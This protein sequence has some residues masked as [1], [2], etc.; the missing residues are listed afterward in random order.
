VSTLSARQHEVLQLIARGL[1]NQEIGDILKISGETVRTHVAAVLVRLEVSNR[2]EAAVAYLAWDAGADRVALALARPALA[3]LPLVVLASDAHAATVALGIAYDLVVLFSRWC[4]FP[5]IANASTQGSRSLG[6]DSREIGERLGARFLIDGQ[7]RSLGTTWR[8][9][10]HVVDVASGYCIWAGNHDFPREALFRVQDEICQQ[11]VAAAYPSLIATVH[12]DLARVPPPEDLA[13][14]ELAHR[15]FP[16]HAAR[17]R[18][19]NARAQADFAAALV[20]EPSLVLA[21]FGLG[22]ATYD[23]IL[24]QWGP[25][26][27]ALDRLAACAERCI[28]LAPH[29]AEG[30]YL[31]ARHYQALGKHGLAVAPLQTAISRN[32]SLASAHALLGQVL[33]IAGQVEEGLLR[34]KHACRLGPGAFVAGLAAA[35]FVCRAYPEALTAAEHAVATNPRYPFARALAVAAAWWADD[36]RRAGVHRRALVALDPTFSSRSFLSTFGPD[37]EAVS[38]IALA[39]EGAARD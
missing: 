28:E 8:L 37:L 7:L 22:L 31:V 27:P 26:S 23:E 16:L 20:R 39:L 2:T 33:L 3:V 15:A 12:A 38:R 29:T 5:V 11:I 21:H 34:M 25:Q 19:A 4:W 30:F 36:R 18:G 35:H 6:R 24:N 9:T 14:W 10:T 32:P 17:E 1:T 13:A